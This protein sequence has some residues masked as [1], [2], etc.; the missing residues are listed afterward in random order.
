MSQRNSGRAP[1]PNSGLIRL[2]VLA[3]FLAASIGPLG[4]F[5]L[6]AGGAAYAFW[7]YRKKEENGSVSSLGESENPSETLSP[8]RHPARPKTAPH[9]AGRRKT[10]SG[11]PLSLSGEQGRCAEE[12]LDLLHAGIIERDEYNDRMRQLKMG[13]SG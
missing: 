12:L 6:I 13:K 2:I 5:L 4:V 1:A 11:T 10:P 9:T 8:V 3:V 7:K